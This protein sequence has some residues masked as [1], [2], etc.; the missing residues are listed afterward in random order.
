MGGLEP[1]TFGLR[2]QALEGRQSRRNLRPRIRPQPD[3]QHVQPLECQAELPLIRK[4][5]FLGVLGRDHVGGFARSL[6]P[7]REVQY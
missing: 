1:L 7:N 2:S 6:I 3:L 5:F 4:T